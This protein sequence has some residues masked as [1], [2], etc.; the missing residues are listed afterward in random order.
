LCAHQTTDNNYDGVDRVRKTEMCSACME[1]F[2]FRGNGSKLN[3]DWK[4]VEYGVEICWR[5]CNG[6]NPPPYTVI[7]R[8]AL[9]GS[10]HPDQC[11]GGARSH[12]I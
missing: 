3:H 4:A 6:R 7:A 12:E 2:C 9:A 1:L 8:N 5:C 11:M 10:I